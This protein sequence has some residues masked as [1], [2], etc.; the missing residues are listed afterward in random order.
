[1]RWLCKT[2]SAEAIRLPK[3]AVDALIVANNQI[4]ADVKEII[5]HAPLVAEQAAP[6]QFIH[7]KVADGEPLLRRPISIAGVDVQ[8]GT[9]RLI[10]RI[11]GKGTLHLANLVEKDQVNCLGPLG[12]G[13]DLDCKRPLLIGGGMGIAPLVFLAQRLDPQSATILMGGR[14][15]AEMFWPPLYKDLVKDIHITTDD[16]SLGAKGFTVDLLPELL[17]KDQY[18]RIF[19]CGPQIMMEAVAS[20]AQKH[21][22]PCQVSLEKHMACGV[23]ACLSCTCASKNE[24][25]R[26]KVCTDGPVFWAGE[27]L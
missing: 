24:G 15:K 16:G 12:K 25:K 9:I 4:T 11:L 2:M 20:L 27:V 22:I 5:I 14:N 6:G 8:K 19:V 18:D 13:F 7:L 21:Q 17:K 26:K 1:M 10:Y 23:G 3:L